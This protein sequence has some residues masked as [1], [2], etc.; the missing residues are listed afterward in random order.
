MPTAFNLYGTAKV[1]SLDDTKRFGYLGNQFENTAS[2]DS[3]EKPILFINEHKLYKIVP[4]IPL[5]A[6]VFPKFEAGARLQYEEMSRQVAFREIA[7]STVRQ[8][9]GNEQE[10][11]AVIGRLVRELPCYKLTFGEEQDGVPDALL[12]IIEKHK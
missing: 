12:Q 4:Q 10:T 2:G 9:A 7:T 6:I 11:V 5:S 1:K 3:V 8:T